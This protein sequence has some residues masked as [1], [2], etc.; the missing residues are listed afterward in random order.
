M[1]QRLTLAVSR[2]LLGKYID[3]CGGRYGAAKPLSIFVFD[4][5][6]GS[7]LRLSICL[8]TQA[9]IIKFGARQGEVFAYSKSE[10]LPRAKLCACAH[11]CGIDKS[12]RGVYN[13]ML[14]NNL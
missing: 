7:A 10:V 13:T 4:D 9:R 6:Y 8:L 2:L 3:A 5:R 14:D 12:A 1:E 11:K